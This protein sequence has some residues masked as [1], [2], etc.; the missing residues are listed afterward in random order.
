MR[1]TFNVLD[2]A[3]LSS[4]QRVIYGSTTWV[5]SASEESMVNEET[6]LGLPSHLYTATKITGE[7]YCHSYVQLYKL[8]VTVLRY[9]FPYGPRA[10]DGAVIPIFVSKALRGEPL[11]L[12]GD[13]MQFRNFV[14]VEDLAEGNVLALQS[15]AKNRTY[16]LVINSHFQLLLIFRLLKKFN[17]NYLI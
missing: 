13:G 3:R 16:N 6:L 10:R 1:G 4:V 12:A 14:Y 11:T 17:V 15:A 7:Y 5:Y 8:D 2:A 9:G